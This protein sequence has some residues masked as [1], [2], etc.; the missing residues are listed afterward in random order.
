MYEIPATER[1]YACEACGTT[2]I[3]K[4]RRMLGPCV[5]CG[6]FEYSEAK[7]SEASTARKKVS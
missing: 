4:E 2:R 3:G 6:R 1:L 7:F 5:N